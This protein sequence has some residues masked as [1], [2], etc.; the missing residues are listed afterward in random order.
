MTDALI[1]CKDLTFRYDG[2]TVVTNLSFQ[3]TS[4]DY[5]CV[6]GENGSGKSTLISGLL[7]LKKPY[8]GSICFENG[9]KQTDVGYLPQQT[10]IQKDFP[11][12]AYEVVISGRLGTEG[13]FPFYRKKD[14]DMASEH[15]EQLGISH[16]RNQCYKELS[17][18]QQQRVL[19]ARALC[20]AK[21]MLILD[22]PVSG[23]DPVVAA[24]LYRL[25]LKI[26]KE[27]NI[28]VVMVTHDIRSAAA[29]GTKILHM[30]GQPLF[31]GSTADYIRSEA[32]HKITGGGHRNV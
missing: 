32:Y 2:R 6:V 4:G 22:E 8:F 20:A 16:L 9:L 5:L 21:R 11:A 13:L 26:N 31:F 28:T 14:K 29:H 19:L 27:L 15:M 30:D 17:G 3:I 12:S 7:G 25:M 18:G 23:L 10:E 1:S 24:E